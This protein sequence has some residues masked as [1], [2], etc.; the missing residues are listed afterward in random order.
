MLRI[1]LEFNWKVWSKS[2]IL[3]ISNTLL[4]KKAVIS[5]AWWHTPL[6]PALRRQRQ[7]DL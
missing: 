6:I 7:A 1:Q 4:D 2:R 5:W 3:V